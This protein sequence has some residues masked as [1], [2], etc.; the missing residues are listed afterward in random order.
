MLHKY[1]YCKNIIYQFLFSLVFT[2]F[3]FCILI[4]YSHYSHAENFG[5]DIL[6]RGIV[7]GNMDIPKVILE[8]QSSGSINAY[9]LHDSVNGYEI[10]EIQKKGILL[11]KGEIV[12]SV[13]L[14]NRSSFGHE[15]EESQEYESQMYT[16]QRDQIEIDNIHTELRSVAG[17]Q[18]NGQ[19]RGITVTDIK[20]GNFMNIMGIEPGDVFL[21]FNET[22]INKPDDLDAA[23]KELI[24]KELV[25]PEDG[26]IRIA[27][28][29]D[30]MYQTSYGDMQ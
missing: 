13:L 20:E 15:G 3:S 23:I 21:E 8:N 19:A 4:P 24:N 9:R 7:N 18:D 30:G 29:R 17:L 22:N 5:Q 10:V 1:F 11:K 16:F 25:N 27:F 28:E 6:I 26:S 14:S 12:V 2:V